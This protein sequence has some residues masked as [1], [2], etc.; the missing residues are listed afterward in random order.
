ML[1]YIGV[2]FGIL[3]VWYSKENKPINY[4]FGI[5]SVICNMYVLFHSKLYA[6]TLLNLYYLM[7]SIYGWWFWL[8]GNSSENAKEAPITYSNMKDYLISIGIVIGTFCIF[9][10]GLYHISDSDVPIWDASVAAFAWAGMWLLAKR[11]MENWIA[12]NISNAL[13]IPL[14]VHKD[15]NVFAVFYSFLFIMAIWGYL[16]WRKII[17]IES[18]RGVN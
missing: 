9:Y 17:K 8:F 12:L 18:N 6:E 5:V 15:L 11:K 16:N 14:M 13:A 2:F 10:F 4:L 3:Q 1:Q 7:M